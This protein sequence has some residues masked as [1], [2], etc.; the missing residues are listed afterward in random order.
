MLGSVG[1]PATPPSRAWPGPQ[2]PWQV[3]YELDFTRL[4]SQTISGSSVTI[5]GVGWSVSNATNADTFDLLEGTGLRVAPKDATQFTSSTRTA[6]WLQV[7]FDDL[8]EDHD[9]TDRLIVQLRVAIAG[10][11]ADYQSYGLMVGSGSDANDREVGMLE[12][13]WATSLNVRSTRM[14]SSETNLD[15][16]VSAEPRVLQCAWRAPC[17]ETRYSTPEAWP[18][19]QDATIA[20]YDFVLANQVPTTSDGNFAAATNIVRLWA[21]RNNAAAAYTATFEAIRVLRQQL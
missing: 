18:R 1:W 13:I 16:S 10:L 11:S 19:P 14:I 4:P 8:M 3:A 15:T 12:T 20:S 17:V 9:R 6:P 21:E 2:L 7:E 5:G